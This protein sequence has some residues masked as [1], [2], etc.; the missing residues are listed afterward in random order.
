[1]PAE[2]PDLSTILDRL[3]R[4][5]DHKTVG[6]GNA[7]RKRGELL[8]IFTNL[9]RKYDRL[10]VTLEEQVTSSDEALL[11][12]AADLCV[13]AAKYL[14]WIA[15]AH[16]QDF[17]AASDG[18]SANR[19][20]DAAGPDAVREVFAH[21]K[22]VQGPADVRGSWDAVRAT[23]EPLEG[24]FLTQAGADEG[25]VLSWEEKT[26][27]AWALTTASAQLTLAV[28]RQRPDE[29]V[30]LENEIDAMDAKR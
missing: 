20:S 18:T 12:T 29:W 22:E 3:T 16:A 11:D 19:C 8:S 14:T 21:I 15:D 23:F 17:E 28:S 13:Y 5:H 4:L 6:Y 1:M 9:A 2:Q 30:A 26:R 25:R 7:W 10:I 24:S 27:F